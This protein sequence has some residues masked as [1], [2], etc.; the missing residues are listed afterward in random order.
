MFVSV[1]NEKIVA[2]KLKNIFLI[3]MLMCYYFF[4]VGCNFVKIGGIK[5]ILHCEK[6]L[7]GKGNRFF[8]SIP[9]F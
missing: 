8:I 4:V 1:K 9:F 7:I 2:F 6:V 3:K 5:F